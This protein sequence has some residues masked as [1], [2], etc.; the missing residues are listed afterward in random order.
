MNTIKSEKF[1][2]WHRNAE[3]LCSDSGK[4]STG[5]FRKR[6]GSAVQAKARC[7]GMESGLVRQ[8]YFRLECVEHVLA[9]SMREIIGEIP[10]LFTFRTLQEG[11]EQAID[12]VGVSEN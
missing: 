12:A 2:D 5:D 6:K 7:S 1:R 11:G 3:N 10:L 4:N 8:M 9:V